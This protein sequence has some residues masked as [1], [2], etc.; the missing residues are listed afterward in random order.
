MPSIKSNPDFYNFK[1]QV[2]HKKDFISTYI[3]EYKNIYLIGHSVGAKVCVELM[4]DPN[5]A[6]RV[7]Q[8][9]LVTPTLQHIANTPNGAFFR[10]FLRRIAPLLISLAWVSCL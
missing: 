2:K 1:G 8:V 4:K 10:V 7:K 5:F 3:P 6:N 9:H